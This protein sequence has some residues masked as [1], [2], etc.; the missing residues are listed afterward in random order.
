MYTLGHVSEV[1]IDWADEVP[2]QLE[3]SLLLVIIF[4]HC[5]LDQGVVNFVVGGY[6]HIDDDMF[7]PAR[8]QTEHV[9]AVEHGL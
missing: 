8:S 4:G 6:R 1:E 9:D 7:C 5:L 3:P 2:T